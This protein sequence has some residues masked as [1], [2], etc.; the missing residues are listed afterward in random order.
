MAFVTEIGL[1]PIPSFPDAYFLN[2]LIDVYHPY[3]AEHLQKLVECDSDLIFS[4]IQLSNTIENGDLDIFLPKLKLP[5]FS[6]K[7]SQTSFSKKGC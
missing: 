7:N 4:S 6:P 2:N 1:E 3:L 5:G